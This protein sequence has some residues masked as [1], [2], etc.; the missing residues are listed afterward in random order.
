MKSTIDS[1]RV[2]PIG[3]VYNG[4]DVWDQHQILV[5]GYEDTND[6]KGTL[7][8]YDSNSPHQYGDTR[9]DTVTLDFTGS[10]LVATTPSDFGTTLAGFF[11]SKYTQAAPPAGLA[12]SFGQFLSFTGDLR[13]WFCAYGSR[14][15]AAAPTEVAILGG[16]AASVLATGTTFVAKIA[17]RP[18]DGALLREHSSAPVYLY[19]GGAPFFVPNPTVLGSFGGW[20]AVRVVPDFGLAGFAASPADDGTLLRSSPPQKCT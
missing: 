17:T 11:V 19:Q 6:G 16:N 7:F 20:P 9:H 2:C 1:G 13:T 4:R 14:M 15:P 10:K 8:V 5:Y 12:P 3:L 18:R